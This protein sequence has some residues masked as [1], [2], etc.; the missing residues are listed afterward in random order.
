MVQIFF[1]PNTW[2]MLTFLNP[3]DVLIPKIPFSFFAEFW[4]RVTARAQ[5]SVSVGFWGARQLSPFWGGGPSQRA[6]S[7]P[8]PPPKLKTRPASSPSPAPLCPVLSTSHFPLPPTATTLVALRLGAE[9]VALR[10]G[11]SAWFQS[12]WWRKGGPTKGRH[13]PRPVHRPTYAPIR[14]TCP[15]PPLQ[16]QFY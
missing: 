4:I 15:P 6:L 12:P 13:H 7:N 1:S 14:I 2:Q 10:G 9:S 16:P 11:L 3:L 5:G 8:P